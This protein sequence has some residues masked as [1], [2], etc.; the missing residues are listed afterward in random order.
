MDPLNCSRSTPRQLKVM[1]VED[2]VEAD[3]F[4]LHNSSPRGFCLP[5]LRLALADDGQKVDEREFKN[6]NSDGDKSLEDIK[7]SQQSST[8]TIGQIYTDILKRTIGFGTKQTTFPKVEATTN[9]SGGYNDYDDDINVGTDEEDAETYSQAHFTKTSS[10]NGPANSN[11]SFESYHALVGYES[12]TT[13]TA[14]PSVAAV[15]SVAIAAAAAAAAASA[16]QKRHRTRFTPGQLNELERVF[17]KTHYPDIFM[18]EE[19]ALRIG[20]T[21][22]RVQSDWSGGGDGV[23]DQDKRGSGGLWRRW[24]Y[25]Q[26]EGGGTRQQMLTPRQNNFVLEVKA[27]GGHG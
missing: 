1:Q 19:L 14:T 6:L 16:K 7:Q 8:S 27:T 25:E 23:E 11:G 9:G 24:R 13:S 5:C 22:S 2:L 17:A 20:L 26:G 12:Q 21:E 10:N 3:T 15:S 18:R 4:P